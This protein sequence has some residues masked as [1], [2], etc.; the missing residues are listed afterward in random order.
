MRRAALAAILVAA[1]A[2][3]V[4]GYEYNSRANTPPVA[5]T[6]RALPAVPV[7]VAAAETRD[8]PRTVRAIGAVESVAT[9]ALKARLDSQVMEVHFKDGQTVKAGDLLFTL[10]DR[11]LQAALAEAEAAL[12][13]DQAQEER[14]ALAVKRYGDLAKQGWTPQAQYEQSV[15][16]AKTAA[17]T[18]AADRA[19]VSAARLQLSYTKITAPIDGRA[20]ATLVTAG[21]LVRANDAATTLVTITQMD[22]IRVSFAI[23][24]AEFA[25]VRAARA[26]GQSPAVRVI[27][28]HDHRQIATGALD[29]IDNQI[30]TQSGTIKLRATVDNKDQPLWPGQFVEVEMVTGTDMAAT[31][32]PAVAV[33][34][35]QQGQ[36]VFVVADDKVAVRPVVVKRMEGDIAVLTS[37]VQPGE[38]VVIDGQAKLVDGSAVRTGPVAAAQS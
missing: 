15:A 25:A 37:G 19:L 28:S 2:A 12:R 4:V 22:P 30:D 27:D 18:V 14:T 9:V 17:A 13:R 33:Q 1:A 8:V 32:L 6:P 7:M 31:T 34:T 35:G 11:P 29:F 10:D 24:E 21:N 36:Y 5:A 26:A 38:R 23:P 20:G 3:G 16:D